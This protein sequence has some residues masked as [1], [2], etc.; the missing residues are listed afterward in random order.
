[1]SLAILEGMARTPQPRGLRALVALVKH[2]LMD[3]PIPPRCPKCGDDRL[4]DWD[5]TLRKYICD[6]C[7]HQWRPAA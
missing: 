5:G 3:P 4:V 6:V 7:S 2:L 1:V